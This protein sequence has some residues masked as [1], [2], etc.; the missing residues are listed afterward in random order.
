MANGGITKQFFETLKSEQKLDAL[1]DQQVE[2]IQALKE[3]QQV[4]KE[5]KTCISQQKEYCN[6]TLDIQRERCDARFKKLERFAWI[7]LGIVLTLNVIVVPVVVYI[8]A[9]HFM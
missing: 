6:T 5:S 2:I 7:A 4:H 3:M 1:F 8:T 9:N